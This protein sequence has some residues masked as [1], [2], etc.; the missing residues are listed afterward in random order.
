MRAKQQK[1]ASSKN[2]NRQD[3]AWA[4]VASATKAS[5][6]GPVLDIPMQME[7]DASHTVI[8]DKPCVEVSD[9]PLVTAGHRS[10]IGEGSL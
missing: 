10:R 7:R 9:I 5:F 2:D 8:P 3:Q 4:A 1:N 6:P